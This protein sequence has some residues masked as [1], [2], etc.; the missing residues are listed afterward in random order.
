MAFCEEEI[1]RIGFIL[2]QSERIEGDRTGF[3][4]V[5][6]TQIDDKLPID[7]DPDVVITRELKDL[8]ASISEGRMQLECEVVVVAETLFAEQ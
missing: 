8:S 6:A 1:K 4:S 3:S 5:D 2:C 7:K